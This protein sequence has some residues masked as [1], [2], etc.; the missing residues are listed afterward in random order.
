MSYSQPVARQTSRVACA[1]HGSCADPWLGITRTYSRFS[2]AIA[3]IRLARVYGGLHFMTAD[4]QA[5][6][7]GRKV[8]DW[9]EANIFQP[10]D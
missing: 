5:V 10:V 9:R 3:E 6:T 2:E 7:L 1:L 8:A 4:A